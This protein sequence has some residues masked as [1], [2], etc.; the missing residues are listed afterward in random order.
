MERAT[1]IDTLSK[2]DQEYYINLIINI[3][4]RELSERLDDLKPEDFKD[5]DTLREF[6]IV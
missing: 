1:Y 3:D 4:K 6:Q 2:E 5:L